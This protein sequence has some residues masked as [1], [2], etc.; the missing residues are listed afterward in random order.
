MRGRKTKRKFS[1]ISMFAMKKKKNKE[2]VKK[3]EI[4]A[5]VFHSGLIALRG[6]GERLLIGVHV[7]YV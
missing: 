2:L 3:R 7:P 6:A 4:V 5:V 1:W